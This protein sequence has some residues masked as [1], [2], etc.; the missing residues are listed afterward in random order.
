MMAPGAYLIHNE[1]RPAIDG[2][3]TA[4]GLTPTQARTIRIGP[5]TKAPLFDAFAIYQKP[6]VRK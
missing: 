6:R 3:A 1:L 4:A 5:G 2:Y